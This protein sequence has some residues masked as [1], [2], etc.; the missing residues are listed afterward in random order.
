[1]MSMHSLMFLMI[2]LLAVIV[3]V[4]G[5]LTA[6]RVFGARAVEGDHPRPHQ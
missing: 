6:L 1:M 3:V 4:G 2:G 5:L